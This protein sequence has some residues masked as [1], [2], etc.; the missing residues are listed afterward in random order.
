MCGTERRPIPPSRW[1]A[2]WRS[3]SDLAVAAS[4][5]PT[6][7]SDSADAD[8]GYAKGLRTCGGPFPHLFPLLDPGPCFRRDSHH[9]REVAI[10][11]RR[12][13]PLART[14]TR[15]AR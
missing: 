14:S 9:G 10:L 15:G 3:D 8:P 12:D 7:R 4:E 2:R 5:G 11:M 6:T 13:L 1:P